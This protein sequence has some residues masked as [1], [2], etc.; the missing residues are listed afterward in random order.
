MF[1]LL[2]VAL[3]AV[4]VIDAR[5][6]AGDDAICRPVSHR[7]APYVVCEVD[8][9]RH[10][11]KLFL[12]DENGSPLGHFSALDD[13]VRTGGD[14][15]VMAMNGGMYHRDRSPVGHYVEDGETRLGVNLREGP[16]NFH[17]LPNGVFFVTERGAGVLESAA[18][19]AAELDVLYATQS[20]PMLVIDGA[21]HPRF[22]PDSDSLKRRNGVGA[23][24][25]GALVFAVS[26]APVRFHDFATLFRDRL[27]APNALYLD[28]TISRLHAPGL[29]RSDP[30]V[31]MGPIIGVVAAE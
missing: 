22:L 3:L 15:L 12:N 28:G 24:E 14:R 7:G 4:G 29:G 8:P 17:M 9:S 27:N 18:Y 31:A 1:A 25:D 19:D 21:L 13:R 26:D 20:G 6:A 5:A 23:R 2:V 30:G 11:V 10:A 16:G